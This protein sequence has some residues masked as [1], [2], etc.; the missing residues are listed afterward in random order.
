MRW[1][2]STN[3][4]GS[5]SRL[6]RESESPL[7]AAEGLADRKSDEPE[8]GVFEVAGACPSTD[9]DVGKVSLGQK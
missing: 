1:R 4:A 6:R 7:G 2:C 8:R 9:D 5:E 3:Y